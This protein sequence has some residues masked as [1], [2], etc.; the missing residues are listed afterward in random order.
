MGIW[1][2]GI[3]DDDM[4]ADARDD[5]V[6]LLKDGVLPADAT[7]TVLARY[8]E[9][10]PSIILAVAATQWT[11]G[12]LSD[13]VKARALRVLADGRALEGWGDD[14]ARMKRLEAV[15]QKL[16]SPAPA[17][18]PVRV[19]A[20]PEDWQP[21]EIL[22]WRVMD[23]RRAVM[24]V[25]G[26]D[27]YGKTAAPTCELLDW[28]DPEPPSQREVR[29]LALRKTT[30]PSDLLGPA[31]RAHP[32]FTLGVFMTGEYP[33]RR[34]RRLRLTTD[35][36][37]AAPEKSIGVHWENFD[38]FLASDFSIGWT[39]GTV[40]ALQPKEDRLF[41]LLVLGIRWTPLHHLEVPVQVMDWRK[42]RLPLPGELRA[43]RPRRSRRDPEESMHMLALGTPAAPEHITVLGRRAPKASEK[44]IDG[45]FCLD[46]TQIELWLLENSREL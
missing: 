6:Q 29:T 19:I 23:G 13:E 7:S 2:T 10:E 37:R 45:G 38:D 27:N 25:V 15:A 4:A 31:L 11:W 5:W 24:R 39:R 32:F 28:Y 1:G 8:G 33:H 26:L 14:R 34:V 3:F 41:V 43:L 17:P 40:L 44:G 20:V 12:R 9:D 36:P 46:W 42:K 18:R 21:G 22:S 16:R 35:L 30:H